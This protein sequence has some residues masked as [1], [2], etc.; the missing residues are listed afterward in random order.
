MKTTRR[1]LLHTAGATAAL[2]LA[3]CTSGDGGDDGTESD[4]DPDEDESASGG[5]V[6][7][8]SVEA[9]ADTDENDQQASNPE[10]PTEAARSFVELLFDERYEEAQALFAEGYRDQVPPAVLERTRLGFSAAGGGLETATLEDTGVESGFQT[11]QLSLELDRRTAPLQV[12]ASE[13]AAL[14]G[15]LINGEYE[16]ASYVEPSTFETTEH[17]LDPGD[18]RLGATVAHPTGEEPVP[19]V[20]LVHGSGPSDRDATTAANKPYRDLAEGLASRGIATLRYDKRSFACNV[21]AAEHTVDR[22]TVEDA[23]YAVEWFRERSGVR[24]GEVTVLGHSLGAMMAPE[25]AARDGDLDGIACLAAPARALTAVFLDQI[26]HLADVGEHTPDVYATQRDRWERAAE[27]IRQDDFADDEQ[28][29]G[30]PGALW[31]SLQEYEPVARAEGLSIPQRYLQ[32]NRDYRVT[33]E[34]DFSRWQS[35]FADDAS[36]S[37]STYERLNHVFLPGEGPAVPEAYAVPNEVEPAVV[38]DLA[39]WIVGE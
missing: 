35:A 39:D 8:T 32:G 26:E 28:L 30:L 22:V 13:D 6:A 21:P 1:T 23:L 19:G 34:D 4:A 14:T 18:C 11:V 5:P 17:T 31:R 38:A 2:A 7:N 15:F 36:V 37:L 27:Q 9:S 10:T 20:V 24:A 12:T 29:M 3:G 16:R 33:R 25:I